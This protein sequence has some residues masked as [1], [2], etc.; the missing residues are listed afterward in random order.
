MYYWGIVYIV[1]AVVVFMFKSETEPTPGHK[2]LDIWN[3]YRL[4]WDILKLPNVQI[5]GAIWITAKVRKI[6]LYMKGIMCMYV[7][8][9]VCMYV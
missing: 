6:N 3:T 8:E 7:C 2:S 4:L 5:L 1:A 9:C